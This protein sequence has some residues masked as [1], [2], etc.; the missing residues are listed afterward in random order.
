MRTVLSAALV[1][2]LGATIVMPALAD[3]A[4]PVT[5]RGRACTIEGTS[6]DNQL[7]GTGGRDVICGKGGDDRID[8]KA[9]IDIVFGGDGDDAV[10]GGGGKDTLKGGAGRDYLI[11]GPGADKL[12]GGGGNDECLNAAGGGAD[13]VDGGPDRD[14]YQADGSDTVVRAER[15]TDSARPSRL[16]SEQRDPSGAAE[17][18]QGATAR[19]VAEHP[20]HRH[21]FG[22]LLDRVE[23][24]GR[25][26]HESLF[27]GTHCFEPMMDRSMPGDVD[28]RP[29]AGRTVH[30]VAPCG[31]ALPQ[32]MTTGAMRI[33]EVLHQIWIGRRPAPTPWIETWRTINPAFEHLLWTEQGID[34][35]GLMHVRLYRDFMEAGLH[36][37]A[38]DVARVGYPA[39]VRGRVRRRRFG[40]AAAPARG[41]VHARAVL[42][43]E[44]ARRRRPPP[45]RGAEL[46]SNA[47]MGSVPGHP[48]LA[49]Y[50]GRLTGVR[51]QRL[52]RHTTGRGALTRSLAGWGPPRVQRP[53]AWTFFTTSIAEGARLEP[54]R[55]A[56]LVD[57]GRTVGA[58]RNDSVS[59][60]DLVCCHEDHTAR[61]VQRRRD[62]DHHH[63][64]GAGAEGAARARTGGAAAAGAGV[65]QLRA[66][67]R[68]PRHLLEQPPP[69][70]HATERV[71]GGILWANLHLLFWLSLVPFVDRLDGRERLRA[72]SDRGVRRGAAPGGGRV[73]HPAAHDHRGQGP[74][75]LLR[76]ALGRDVKGKL[77]PVL[78][79]V[80]IL[81]AFVIRGSLAI[82]VF[83][84]LMWLVPDRRIAS[85]IGD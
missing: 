39:P 3:D 65:P 61:G 8:A 46:I 84:A 62:R 76:A 2:G 63:D 66:E 70:A 25:A 43:S 48:V 17:P 72:R 74:D 7:N 78:Y 53:P 81:L 36:D 60:L 27:T 15:E 71:N 85:V 83:V 79:V 59:G 69:H 20:A 24:L 56:L 41:T 34:D 11:G 28:R 23:H 80:A 42:R 38:A 73:L 37:G 19:R 64:H 10:L 51:A 22:R 18:L 31:Q 33:P 57:H 12:L 55:A 50:L 44:G 16:R 67:L 40:R 14:D 26:C 29:A 21:R 77:S 45:S 58:C 13:R 52:L 32:V 35:L 49:D 9:G 30:D 68:V 6:G 75:S 1:L 54:V 4:V 5:A 47:F 82:Y